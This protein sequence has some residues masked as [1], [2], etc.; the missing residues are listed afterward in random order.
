[1]RDSP[2]R[3]GKLGRSAGSSLSTLQQLDC[4]PACVRCAEYI[5]RE[6]Y[7]RR[8][9]GYTGRHGRLCVC[10][11]VPRR[12]PTLLQVPGCDFEG[13]VGGAVQFGGFAIGARV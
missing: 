4:R 13:M 5:S 10:L 7:P 3:C 11:S 2:A 8:S 6:A 1:M 12:I 9:V